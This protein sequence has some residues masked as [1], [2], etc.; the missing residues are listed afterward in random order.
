MLRSGRSISFGLGPW[1][2]PLAVRPIRLLAAMLLLLV[3][4]PF[5]EPFSICSPTVLWSAPAAPPA[6]MPYRVPVLDAVSRNDGGYPPVSL[7]DD[8]LQYSTNVD[9]APQP[10]LS[11][12]ITILPGPARSGRVVQSTPLVLRL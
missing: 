7:T 6:A 11:V 10:R 5:T 9:L 3:A 4:S 1:P 12:F 2:T 8:E